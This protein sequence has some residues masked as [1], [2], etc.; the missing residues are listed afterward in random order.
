MKKHNIKNDERVQSFVLTPQDS[1][2]EILKV[3]KEII[4]VLSKGENQSAGIGDWIPEKEAQKILGK[5]VTSLWDLRKRGKL[6]FTK[7]GNKVFYSRNNI[8]KFMES[9]M[10]GGEYAGR[11]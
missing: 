2:N 3:Q 8:I 1:L 11:K 6:T 9:N 7:V 5:K 4:S 10:K